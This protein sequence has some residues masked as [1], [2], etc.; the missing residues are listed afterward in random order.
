MRTYIRISTPLRKDLMSIFGL[1]RR[2]IYKALNGLVTND[3]SEQIRK[4]ALSHGGET[5]SEVFVPKCKT[6]HHEDGC[7]T[8]VFDNGITVFVNTMD[9]TARI[10]RGNLELE[11]FKDVTLKKWSAIL[12][13]A[14]DYADGQYQN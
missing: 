12:K 10:T 2:S 11:T 6:I 9:S 4:Y 7:F 14:Q 1:S 8:Q 3:K 13:M 5:V